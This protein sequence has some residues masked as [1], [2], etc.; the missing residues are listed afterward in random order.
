MKLEVKILENEYFFGGSTQYT[1]K[2]PISCDTEGYFLDMNDGHNQTMPLYISTFGRCIWCEEP[3]TV[4]A[5]GGVISFFSPREKMRL[6]AGILSTGR[7]P[8][9]LP[10]SGS[11]AMRCSRAAST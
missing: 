4:S 1:A 6:V 8:S 2:L 10:T 3:M 11:S 9:Q 5:N 7:S